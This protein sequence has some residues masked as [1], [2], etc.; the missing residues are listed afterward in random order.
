M[1][2][3]LYMQTRGYFN[4]CGIGCW[5]RA[6]VGVQENEYFISYYKLTTRVENRFCKFCILHFVFCKCHN[7]Q[8][9]QTFPGHYT[10]NNIN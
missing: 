2:I 4:N 6:S 5:Y 7:H 10:L 8:R 1:Y 3:P 9:V